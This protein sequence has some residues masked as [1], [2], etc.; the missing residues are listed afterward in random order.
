MYIHY[1]SVIAG[2]QPEPLFYG[3]GRGAALA[4]IVGV[5]PRVAGLKN[6]YSLVLGLVFGLFPPWLSWQ[7]LSALGLAGCINRLLCF[8]L[9][10]LNFR[11]IIAWPG[12]LLGLGCC[13]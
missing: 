10:W 7:P 11:R 9:S 6:A 13:R 1:T 2:C 5:S 8:H 12:Q 3:I 4:V